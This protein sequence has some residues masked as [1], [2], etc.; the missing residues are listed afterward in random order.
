MRS[1]KVLTLVAALSAC[2]EPAP[3]DLLAG[4]YSLQSVDGHRVPFRIVTVPGVEI[5]ERRLDLSPDGSFAD[6]LR[7]RV[8]DRGRVFIVP[9]D[10]VGTYRLEE[11]LVSFSYESG[12]VADAIW[13]GRELELDDRGVSFVFR[14]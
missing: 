10:L 8:T 12:R 4:E 7:L 1:W 3:E 11:A 9:L 13:D 6:E 14:R 2:V 5:A